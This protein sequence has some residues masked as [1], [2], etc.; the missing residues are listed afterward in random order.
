[1]S[2]YSGAQSMYAKMLAKQE[3]KRKAAAAEGVTNTGASSSA[4][5]KAAAPETLIVGLPVVKALKTPVLV[6]F[7]STNYA[8]M[9]KKA[10]TK[11]AAAPNLMGPHRLLAGFGSIKLSFIATGCS[12]A[13]V[14]AIGAG[15]EAFAWGRNDLGQLGHGDLV[16]RPGPARVAALAK[17]PVAAAATGKSHTLLLTADGEVMA[18]GAARQGCAGKNKNKDEQTTPV[19]VP[20]AGAAKVTQVACGANFNL[21]CDAD[22]GLWSWGWSEFGVLGNDDNGE[23][24]MKE[25]SVKLSYQAQSVPE[26]VAS[27]AAD[28]VKIVHVA[29][30]QAHCAAVSSE[31]SVYTWGNGGYGRLGHKTQDDIWKPKAIVECKARFVSCGAAHTACFGL[32][33]L[34]NGAV[35]TGDHSLFMW[36]RVKSASQNAWMY[37]R[38][39]EELR[40]WKL[41]AMATGAGHNVV[42]A[43]GSLIS[44]GSGT[45]SGELGFGEGGKKSSAS[46]AKVDALEGVEVAQLA[47]GLANTFALVQSCEA[48]EAL[49]LFRPVDPTF[50]PKPAADAKDAKR[51]AEADE[52]EGG[53]AAK[54]AKA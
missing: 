50:P 15:G 5:E 1:M 33:I 7:G 30:G 32:P 35:C 31:G 46:P 39:E 43:D 2:G 29:C 36:G 40:G 41:K 4:P 11:S 52:A 18:C 6:A 20:V 28:D 44:W 47:C 12:S 10:G 45:L 14:V 17:K 51:P 25:G 19:A 13:H 3:E 22:G 42:Y 34:R 9:G 26:R 24:N 21:A 53:A 48:V 23:W 49:P 54:K 38:T 16:M 27:L 37:P 8:E